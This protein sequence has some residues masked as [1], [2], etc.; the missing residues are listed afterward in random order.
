MAVIIVMSVIVIIALA[1]IYIVYSINK[2]ENELRKRC[3][4]QTQGVVIDIIERIS[5]DACENDSTGSI[6]RYYVPVVKYQVFNVVYTYE[7]R[8]ADTGVVFQVGDMVDVCYNPRKPEECFLPVYKNFLGRALVFI[9]A[10]FFLFAG[11]L[12]H[13]ILSVL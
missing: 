11:L 12:V 1:M 5:T 7:S 2:Q 9:V 3:T 13:S 4:L 6:T 8:R 10:I